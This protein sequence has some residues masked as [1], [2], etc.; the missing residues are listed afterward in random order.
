M[1]MAAT[2]EGSLSGAGRQ[3]P[4]REGARRHTQSGRVATPSSAHR[5]SQKT[6]QLCF[7]R[8]YSPPLRES[9]GK[10]KGDGFAL[11]FWLELVAVVLD[12]V[13]LAAA[14]RSE[15]Q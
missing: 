15:A 3:V 13:A 9:S 10:G 7:T 6:W 5:T 14:A 1:G 2:H 12:E 11:G 4:P 8:W